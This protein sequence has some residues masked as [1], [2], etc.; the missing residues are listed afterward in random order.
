MRRADVALRAVGSL[1]LL[2]VGCG[3]DEAAAPTTTTVTV[4]LGEPLPVGTAYEDPSGNVTLT[5]R[6]IRLTGGLLLADAEACAA[7]GGLPA[8][9]VQPDAWQLRLE[10]REQ[11]IP[12][13]I[14]GQPNRAARPPWPEAARVAAGECVEGKVAFRVPAQAEPAEVLFT[15]L[16]TPVAWTVRR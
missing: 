4:T 13:V 7:T 16:P 5:V 12:Q 9:P 1:A 10:G 8:L 3:D 14:L 2:L 15:Q 6:G 11:T